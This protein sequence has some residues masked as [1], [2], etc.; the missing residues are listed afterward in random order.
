MIIMI[1]ISLDVF[2]SSDYIAFCD[3][4]YGLIYNTTAALK[5]SRKTSKPC[6]RTAS[7]GVEK[8]TQDLPNMRQEFYSLDDL[9]D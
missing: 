9:L 7:L 2:D 4:D 1:Y 3:T 6:L 8:W 5:L